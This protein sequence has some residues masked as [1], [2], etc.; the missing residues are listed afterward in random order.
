MFSFGMSKIFKF[1]P[2]IV[3]MQIKIISARYGIHFKF[4]IDV[5]YNVFYIFNNP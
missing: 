5:F 3:F 2:V 1:K 4:I